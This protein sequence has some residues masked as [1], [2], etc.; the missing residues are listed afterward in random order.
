MNKED[1]IICRCREVTA[2][3]IEEA[4]D[5][6]ARAL[7]DVKRRVNAGMGLCQGKSCSR[8]IARMISDKTGIPLSDIAPDSARPPVRPLSLPIIADED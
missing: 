5:S 3:Q 6:G 8:L 4:I 7:G 1:L 2:A